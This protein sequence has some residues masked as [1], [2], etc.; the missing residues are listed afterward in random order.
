MAASDH[1]PVYL[2]STTNAVDL[3]RRL[4]FEAVDGFQMLI[5]KRGT[6]VPSEIYEEVCMLWTPPSPPSAGVIEEKLLDGHAGSA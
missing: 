5:P 2:E 3:Y 4:G 6:E 1:L